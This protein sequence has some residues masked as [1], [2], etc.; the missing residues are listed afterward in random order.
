MVVFQ[1]FFQLLDSWKVTSWIKLMVMGKSCG[2]KRAEGTNLS[3][4]D[5]KVQIVEEYGL[6]VLAR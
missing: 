3:V 5:N 2:Q 1:N 6:E 4:I